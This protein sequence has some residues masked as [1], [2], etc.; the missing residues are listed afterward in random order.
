MFVKENLVIIAGVAIG[1]AVILVSMQVK[2][3]KIPREFVER[4]VK[5]PNFKGKYVNFLRKSVEQT[6]KNKKHSKCNGKNTS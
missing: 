2:N 4:F 3:A 6:K 1:I 5:S